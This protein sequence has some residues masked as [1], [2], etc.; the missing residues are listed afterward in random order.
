MLLLLILEWMET[1]T[2][3]LLRCNLKKR[4]AFYLKGELDTR[5][6]MLILPAENLVF[7]CNNNEN[8]GV[9]YDHR[10]KRISG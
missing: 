8:S 5:Q 7:H 1:I 3:T 2:A 9:V 10:N 4:T 6:L